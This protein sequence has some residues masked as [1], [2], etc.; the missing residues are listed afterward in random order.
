MTEQWLRVYR[1]REREDVGGRACPRGVVKM[2]D[3]AAARHCDNFENLEF[4]GRVL[5]DSR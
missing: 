2:F 5:G 1:D 3:N 4:G